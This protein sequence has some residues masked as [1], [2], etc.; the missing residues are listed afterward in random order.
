MAT[1]LTMIVRNESANLSDCL[2]SVAGL[3]DE[4]IVVDTGSTDDTRDIARAFGARVFDFAWCDDFS[5]ARNESLDRASGD[6]L[7]WMD[8]DDRLQEES[9]QPF[10]ALLASL[11]EPCAYSMAVTSPHPGGE[12]VTTRKIRLFHRD[13]GLRWVWRVH[14]NL[15]PIGGVTVKPASVEFLHIGNLDRQAV[16]AKSDRNLAL[17]ALELR[18]RPNEP[19]LYYYLGSEWLYQGNVTMALRCLEKCRDMVG[20]Q[21]QP[22]RWL[23]LFHLARC[24]AAQ[25]RWSLV[26]ELERQDARLADELQRRFPVSMR[27]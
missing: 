6:W 4:T 14:E 1:S 25:G 7:A 22:Y 15:S 11:D 5:A 2:Q 27:S 3:F 17:L 8:A 19:S 21:P 12:R 9:R 18:E 10:K 16:A 26:A 13:L 24:Y 23:M 20:D